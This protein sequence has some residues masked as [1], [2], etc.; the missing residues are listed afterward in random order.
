MVSYAQKIVNKLQ[1]RGIMNIQ[2]V[3]YNDE[4]YML[5]VNP[6][7]SRTVPVVSKVC[8]TPLV[9]AINSNIAWEIIVGN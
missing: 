3:I 9:S 7:A 2:Y 6:R 5:E 1:Y 8:N 4:V